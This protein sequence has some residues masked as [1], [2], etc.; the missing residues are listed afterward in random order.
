MRVSGRLE[1]DSLDP[2]G[3]S[4]GMCDHELSVLAP[5][6]IPA[7]AVQPAGRSEYPGASAKMKETSDDGVSDHRKQQLLEGVA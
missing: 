1:K 2:L 4:L 7:V 5:A 6:Q 3:S